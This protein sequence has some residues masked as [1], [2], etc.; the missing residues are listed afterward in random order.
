MDVVNACVPVFA[1][2]ESFHLRY[3]WLKKAYEQVKDNKSVFNDEH[4]T[5][6]L[7]VGK[8]MVR[9]MKFWGL[10][11]KLFEE[12]GPGKVKP[13]GIGTAL[14][15]DDGYDPYLENTETLW[16]IHWLL[17]SK[18]CMLPV[19][20]LIMNKFSTGNILV[21]DV[22]QDIEVG[23][24]EVEKW[25]TPS[26]N[27]VK[28][29]IDAFFHTYVAKDNSPSI[30]EYLDCPLRQ[31]K[32]VRHVDD[33]MRFSYGMKDGLSSGVITYACLD[34]A[35][36]AGITS[37]SIPIT[38]LAEERGSVG[39]AFKISEDDIASLLR[40]ITGIGIR[41]DNTGGTEHII[42]EP[43]TVT[44]DDILELTYQ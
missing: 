14:L 22:K 25:T 7:G 1:R 43:D 6:L 8:N 24:R 4:A 19:W 35:K 28:R 3:G 11:S 21:N 2:H 34:Y 31:L 33:S 23:V 18:P 30:D 20:W 36:N 38:R 17:L 37:K 29:D 10:A 39:A 12:D 40:N 27:S 13:T 15:D 41:V 16:L 42:L 9:A 44:M 32:L 5:V 26:M